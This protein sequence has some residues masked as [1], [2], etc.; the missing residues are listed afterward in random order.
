MVRISLGINLIAK[1]LSKYHIF[2]DLQ[3]YIYTEKHVIVSDCYLCQ[4][5]LFC[6]CLS[7]GCVF[8][9]DGQSMLPDRHIVKVDPE[10]RPRT[11]GDQGP[12][13]HC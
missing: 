13:A 6:P 9:I 8:G 1:A 7:Y 10:A 3:E 5:A 4:A 11:A 12:L 2:S